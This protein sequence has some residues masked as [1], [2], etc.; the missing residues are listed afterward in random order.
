MALFRWFELFGNLENSVPEQ[1]LAVAYLIKTVIIEQSMPVSLE[2]PGESA[3]PIT[4]SST[5]E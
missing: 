3:G 1:I 2:I 4:R 5:Q